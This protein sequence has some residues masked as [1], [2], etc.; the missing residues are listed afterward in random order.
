MLATPPLARSLASIAGL[1]AACACLNS[2]CYNPEPLGCDSDDECVGA[3]VCVDNL[4]QEASLSANN[5]TGGQNNTTNGNTSNGVANNSSN[6]T[7][8]N[9]TQN[10]NGAINNG[11]TCLRLDPAQIDFALVPQGGVERIEQIDIVNCSDDALQVQDISL[12]GDDALRISAF[13]LAAPPYTLQ[14]GQSAFVEVTLGTARA[15]GVAQGGVAVEVEEGVQVA[16]W[17]A[18]FI[19][20]PDDNVCPRAIATASSPSNP[21]PSK[22]IEGIPAGETIDFDGTLSDD[23][24]GMVTRYRWAIIDQP[25]TSTARLSSYDTSTTT[26]GP[27]VAG[28]YSIQLNVFDDFGVE[29]CEA[30][31]IDLF[32]EE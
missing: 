16:T 32:V 14:P 2:G 25:I 7:S 22:V 27:E 24:D 21:E 26:F 6:P 18:E 10:T 19:D 1:L 20:T 31:E 5:A 3:R 9:N 15:A 17:R 30:S 4:C 29:S 12:T 28:E 11:S 8:P 23:F 13:S